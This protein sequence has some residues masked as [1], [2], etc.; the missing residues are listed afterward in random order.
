MYPNHCQ[1]IQT[2]MLGHTDDDFDKE[3]HRVD[4]QQC[5]DA[6]LALHRGKC[7]RVEDPHNRG[8]S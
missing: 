4:D 6:G 8:G 3:E 1:G 2:E 7:S 5:D